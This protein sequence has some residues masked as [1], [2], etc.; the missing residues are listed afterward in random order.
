MEKLSIFKIS[1]KLLDK[2]EEL[3][4]FL[5]GFAALSG[6]KILVHGGGVHADQL[7]TQLGLPIEMHEG[8]R[9]TSPAMRDLVTMVYG[10]LLN[11]QIVAQLQMLGADAIGLTGADARV[12]TA[13][14]RRPEP[15]DFGCVGDIRE[16]RSD[17]L[18]DLMVQDM[19][20]VLAPISWEKATGELL[21]SN[22]DGVACQVT[23]AFSGRYE[24][25]LYYCFDKPGV[26]LDIDDQSSLLP[27]IDRVQ[28]E[29]LKR[30][31]KVQG[32]MLPK[33]DSCF[34]AKTLGAHRVLLA[35]PQDSLHYAR[36]DA[37]RGTM[38]S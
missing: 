5:R 37:F 29:R 16:V 25:F 35:S 10:G 36:G 15:I 33:L 31:K 22:A 4:T 20:P 21:N 8:R 17:F 23:Q 9:I 32:G 38:I 27:Q 26:L 28:Y 3:Q 34:Q 11:K 13:Q 30:E 7:A 14:R 12:F 6:K 1:G 18:E 19:I 24:T 2:S